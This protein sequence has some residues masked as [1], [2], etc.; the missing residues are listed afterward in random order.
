MQCNLNALNKDFILREVEQ[1][2]VGCSFLALCY[3][4]LYGG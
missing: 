1:L 4:A 3:E 2:A